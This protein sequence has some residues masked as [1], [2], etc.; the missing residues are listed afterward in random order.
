MINKQNLCIK[1][2]EPITNP[3]CPTCHLKE[4]EIWLTDYEINPFAIQ[5]ILSTLRNKLKRIESPNENKCIICGKRELTLCSYCF[6]LEAAKI[7]KELNIP[8][9]IVDEFLY[10]FNYRFGHSNYPI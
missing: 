4:M 9:A 8:D 5:I 1:C 10:T 6:F 7:L 2:I 3:V